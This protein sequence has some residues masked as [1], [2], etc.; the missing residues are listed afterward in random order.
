MADIIKVNDNTWRIE[1]G[2]VRFFLLVGNNKAVMIDSGC[3]CPNAKGIGESLTGLPIILLNTHGDGDHTSGTAAF[4]EIYIHKEDYESRN[5]KEIYTNTKLVEV[6][7]KDII[8]LGGRILEIIEIPGH[9][10]G[11]VAILDV[12]NRTLYAGDSVQDGN[13]YMF[14]PHRDPSSYK[15]SLNKLINISDRYDTVIGSHGTP[16]LT[17]DYVSKVLSGWEAVLKGTI[18]PEDVNLHGADTKLYATEYCGFYYSE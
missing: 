9:T 7:D 18:T 15:D 11:S 14:G 3:F 2:F 10:K 17:K 8:D 4:D 13:I 16:E 12:N 5:M 6:H 1:D